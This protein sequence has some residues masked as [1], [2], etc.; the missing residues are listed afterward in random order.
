[1]Y[2]DEDEFWWET[3]KLFSDLDRVYDKNIFRLSDLKIK[4]VDQVIKPRK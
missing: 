4:H 1:M 2:N 3:L